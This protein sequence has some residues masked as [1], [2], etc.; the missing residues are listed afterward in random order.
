LP[1]SFKGLATALFLLDFFAAKKSNENKVL[2]DG[3]NREQNITKV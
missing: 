3:T 2:A 1:A